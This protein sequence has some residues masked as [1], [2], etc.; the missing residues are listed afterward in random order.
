MVNHYQFQEWKL[1]LKN[2]FN[3]NE[4]YAKTIHPIISR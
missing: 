2:P 1:T 4:Y 3:L